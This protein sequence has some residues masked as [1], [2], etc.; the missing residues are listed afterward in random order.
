RINF[1]DVAQHLASY[2]MAVAAIEPQF[3]ALL[4]Q[5]L[6]IEEP[7]QWPQFPPSEWPAIKAKFAELFKTKSR[8]HWCALLEG[9]DACVA[10]VLSMTEAP[11]HPHNQA[12]NTFVTAFGERQP[13]PAPRFEGTPAALSRPPNPAP[14][15][16]Q[17]IID[18]WS[19]H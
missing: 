18:E 5:K 19:A 9:T 17:T 2:G 10:P 3:Y 13:G 12:R 15:P 11:E 8:D 6:G 7:A 16:A 1:A 14:E 4:L